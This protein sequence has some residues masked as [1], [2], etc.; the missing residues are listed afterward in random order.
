MTTT[1]GGLAERVNDGVTGFIA[2]PGRPDSRA[3]AIDRALTVTP[4]H[5]D[6]MRRAGQDEMASRFDHDATVGR[7]VRTVAPWTT[8]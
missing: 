3:T 6:R 8:R 1:A 7:F 5:R 4:K 2:E